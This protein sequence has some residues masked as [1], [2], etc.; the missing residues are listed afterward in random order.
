MDPDPFDDRHPSRIDSSC[1]L[2]QMYKVLFRKNTLM[3]T[4]VM[5]YLKDNHWPRRSKDNHDLNVAACRLIMNLIPGLET[6]VVFESPAND[7]LIQKL[8]T[9]AENKC[10]P[11]QTYALGL[12][13]SCME[14]P[15]I[16]ANFK[17]DNNKLVPIIL[18]RLQLYYT[19]FTE[20]NEISQNI[21]PF[22]HL[23]NDQ[24]N[25]DNTAIKPSPAK[26][27]NSVK[28]NEQSIPV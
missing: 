25:N 17:E 9:W 11:L 2:G 8:F 14:L 24:T 10:E 4:L 16:A 6:A 20:K 12:L 26:K 23:N 1:L 27:K 3:N 7:Q 5:D 28:I 21:K 18:D 22:S 13:A 15:D 19:E